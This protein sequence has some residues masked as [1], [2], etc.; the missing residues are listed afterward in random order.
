MKAV[1]IKK[2]GGPENLTIEKNY[3]TPRAAKGQVLIQVK[4]FGI[5]RAELHMREGHWPEI[6]P[7]IGIECVG[8]VEEDPSG[9][10]PKGQKVAAIMGGMGRSINGSY[11]QYVCAPATNVIPIT[12]NLSWDILASIPESFASAWGALQWGLK[13]KKGQTILVRGATSCFGLAAIQLAKKEG[14][15]VVATTRSNGKINLLKETGADHVLLENKQL[16]NQLKQ[17]VPAKVNGVLELIGSTTLM[18]STKLV[19]RKG[20]VCMAGFL[21]GRTFIDKSQPLL[22]WVLKRHGKKFALPLPNGVKVTFF[23][24]I[25]FGTPNF[26]IS[27]LPL[28]KIVTDIEEGK[29]PGIHRKTF[30]FDNIV[31]A[32]KFVESN[33]VNGKVVVTLP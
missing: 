29:M 22:E 23:G 33:S 31:E 24:S 30:L 18:N 28:Q 25:V 15:T 6:A 19:R 10:F 14:L 16:L 17:I 1:L 2:S 12:T 8:I 26:P 27:E 4:A 11:A 3:E 32:H 7:I 9:V 5:N 20:T 13:I 21:G